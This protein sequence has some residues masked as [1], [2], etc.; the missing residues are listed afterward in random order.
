[1]R[2]VRKFYE[3]NHKLVD[4]KDRVESMLPDIR[5][6]TDLTKFYVAEEGWVNFI[7]VID[8]CTREC[9]GKRKS[10]RG[11]GGGGTNPIWYDSKCN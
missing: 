1:M 10:E 3:K 5:W 2:G 9:I 8:C 7:P 6:S 11:L 4:P